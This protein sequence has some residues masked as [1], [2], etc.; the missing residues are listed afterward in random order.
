MQDFFEQSNFLKLVEF[1][2][3]KEGDLVKIVSVNNKKYEHG[4]IDGGNPLKSRLGS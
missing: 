3:G 1:T 2:S 4:I